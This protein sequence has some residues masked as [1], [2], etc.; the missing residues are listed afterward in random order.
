MEA[1]LKFFE[2]L[3]VIGTA[4]TA[5][6][7]LFAAIGFKRWGWPPIRRVFTNVGGFCRGIGAV[8]ELP[9]YIDVLRGVKNMETTVDRIHKEVIP[10]GGS[11]LRDAVTMTRDT[12]KR[13][14]TALALFINTSRAQWDGMGMFAVFECTPDGGYAYTNSVYQRW[15]N[16]SDTELLGYGWINALVHADR[17]RVRV[18]WDSCVEDRREFAMSFRIR[19]AHGEEIPVLCTATPVTETHHGPVAKWVGVIRR[20][21]PQETGAMQC[22]NDSGL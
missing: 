19:G 7:T 13:T 16:R 18:E 11:S 21:N 5:V 15:T 20:N 1:A 3:G 10:N 4:L 2:G 8:S 22:A 9:Q 6:A 14:E 17:E 12:V